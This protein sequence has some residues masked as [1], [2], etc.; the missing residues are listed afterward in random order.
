MT[1]GV[2]FD[3]DGVLIDSETFYF[4]RRMNFFQELEIDP[5]S[6]QIDD[7]VGKTEAAIWET[8]VPEDKSLREELYPKYVDYRKT[9]PIDF[10]KDLRKEVKPL[11]D[12]LKKR[13]I[14]LALASSSPVVEIE[15]MLIQCELTEYFSFV[16]SG[17]SLKQSKPHP[18]IYL[19]AKQQ[20]DCDFFIAV[21]DSTIG[22]KSAKAANIYTVALKQPMQIDQSEADIQIES[23]QE[24]EQIVLEKG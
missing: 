1:M 10:A 14:P 3:M 4:E 2:I 9:H 11:L 23:L 12:F 19:K 13:D 16:I 7:Y 21:E 18:E 24:L 20:L 6:N 8:L 22:I 5:G 17:E 15:S